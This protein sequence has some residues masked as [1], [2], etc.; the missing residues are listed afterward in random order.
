MW[1]DVLD[2]NEFYGT[3]LGQMTGRLLRTRL[4]EVW[5]NVRG[6]TVLGLGYAAPFLRPFLDEAERVMAFMPAQQGVTRWPREGHNHT[7]LVDEL[8]L[9]LAD[10]SVD[11]VLLVHAIDCTEQ[12]RP[13][14]REIWRVLADGGRLIAVAPTR[15]GLWSQIDRSP[16]YQGHPYSAGQL[17]S[18]LR[19]NMFAPMR[20]ARALYMPPT[21]SRLALRMAPA[22]ERF[23]Q[24]WL[25]RFAGVS[26]IEAGKQLYAG[27]AERHVPE[28]A[29]VRPKLRIASSRDSAQL[30]GAARNAHNKDGE[31][32]AS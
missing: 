32:P 26:V 9:P 11:R 8:D 3:T 15:A 21:H 19:A 6:E 20:Q 30:P 25:G 5:P 7:A 12:V 13:M 4:R 10:R 1:T 16:F 17:A 14:L 29:V 18:L 23:G 31:A 27:I 2:L 24:R 28:L 22:V